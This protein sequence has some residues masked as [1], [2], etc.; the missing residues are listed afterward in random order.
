MDAMQD[1]TPNSG[2]CREVTLKL[3]W[4]HLHEH[5]GGVQ[6]PQLYGD[7][8]SNNSNNNNDQARAAA[9][10][11]AAAAAPPGTGP[12]NGGSASFVPSI[13]DGEAASMMDGYDAW[14]WM[15][16]DTTNSGAVPHLYQWPNVEDQ[17]MNIFYGAAS[18]PY[19][20]GLGGNQQME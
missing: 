9:A 19:Y 2:K 12:N 6:Q 10:A 18:G 1:L 3:C 13:G 5:E 16:Q 4:P 14:C 15:M 17:D 11:A 20:P 7:D 8:N